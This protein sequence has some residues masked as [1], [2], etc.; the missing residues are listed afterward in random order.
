MQHSLELEAE[1]KGLIGTG[2]RS[3]D[4]R[5][6][7]L[8][9]SFKDLKCLYF[10]QHYGS[11]P[12]LVLDRLIDLGA[13]IN[14]AV[15]DKGETLLFYVCDQI[16]N[17]LVTGEIDTIKCDYGH[18]KNADVFHVKLQEF[19]L[20]LIHK[21][22]DPMIPINDWTSI[23]DNWTPYHVLKRDIHKA[24]SKSRTFLFHLV[25][26]IKKARDEFLETGSTQSV[27]VRKMD[28]LDITPLEDES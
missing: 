2:I 25:S 5:D 22:A 11:L 24:T 14:S 6:R 23:H 18:P 8:Y 28:I 16:N 1:S 3:Q 13:D 9:T 15:G 10:A 26:E 7:L 21:G 19:V 20:S 12:R 4:E 27:L 17:A